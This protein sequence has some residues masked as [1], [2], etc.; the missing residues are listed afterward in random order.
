MSF[1]LMKYYLVVLS[2]SLLSMLMGCGAAGTEVAN[3][4]T[5]PTSTTTAKAAKAVQALFGSRANASISLKIIKAAEGDHEKSGGSC[6]PSTSDPACT[7]QSVADATATSSTI[8]DASF[9][10]PD[11][12]GSNPSVTLTADHFCTQNDGTTP[13]TGTGVDENGLFAK[14]TL[15]AAVTASC[16]DSTSIAMQAGSTGVWRNTTAAQTTTAH[17]P[18]I[19]GTF[20]MLINNTD[21]VTMSCTLYLGESEEFLYAHCAD[22]NGTAV[23]QDSTSACTITSSTD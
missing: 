5:D 15:T 6:T 16:S 17:E 13:N 11:T 18:E 3:P 10:T 9:S 19:Y 23:T 12:Y 4:P 14:F 7:C 21:T 8:E 20:H 2:L 22:E 1:Y